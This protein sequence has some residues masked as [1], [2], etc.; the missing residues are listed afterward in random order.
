MAFLKVSTSTPAGP[1]AAPAATHR[2][3]HKL[4]VSE[5]AAARAQAP[6]TGPA[7]PAGGLQG[8]TVY[9]RAT[10]AVSDSTVTP[11]GARAAPGRRAY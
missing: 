11:R 4:P 10:A 5:S 9:G 3:R 6:L 8:V 2:P 7:G 1:G